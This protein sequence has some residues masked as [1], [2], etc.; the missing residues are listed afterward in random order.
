VL[1]DHLLEKLNEQM[2]HEF[3][4]SNFY[5]TMAAYCAEENYDGF[6]HF[7]LMQ[8]EEERM[9][10]MKI[11][12]FIHTLGNRARISGLDSPN[13]DYQSVLQAFEQA[14]EHEQM[15]TKRIYELSDIALNE[16]EHATINFLKWFIDEQVEEESTFDGLIQKLK[17]IEDDSNAL[18]MLD[19]ELAKRPMP[20]IE[21]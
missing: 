19:L 6:S 7:F 5:L 11:F 17:R 2:N 3:F 18:F 8:S 21:A 12:H 4:S 1:S 10:A 14:Y 20:V 15:V 13:N 16:R 9:H